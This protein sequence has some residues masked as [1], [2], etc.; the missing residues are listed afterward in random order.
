VAEQPS[1]EQLT[2]TEA[3]TL[4]RN[5]Q[6]LVARIVN[7]GIDPRFSESERQRL[8]QTIKRLDQA[9][10]PYI[11]MQQIKKAARFKD[12]EFNALWQ[13]SSYQTQKTDPVARRLKDEIEEWLR[14]P[15]EQG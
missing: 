9:N 3:V 11:I 1:A 6:P 10:F 12:N 14:T 2:E 15:P 7:E 13:W 8:W 5:V 4:L